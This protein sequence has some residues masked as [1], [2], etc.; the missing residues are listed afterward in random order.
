MGSYSSYFHF[1]IGEIESQR[2]ETI[3]S[4]GHS[5]RLW[6]PELEQMVWFQKAYYKHPLNTISILK[7]KAFISN[8]SALPTTSSAFLTEV[9]SF[10]IKKWNHGWQKR[11]YTVPIW[12]RLFPGNFCWRRGDSFISPSFSHLVAGMLIK[13]LN[14]DCDF[15]GGNIENAS[16]F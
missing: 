4:H 3:Q 9:L 14:C 8:H 5:G 15:S 2:V 1:I 10:V 7:S 6:H 12:F 11:G 13:I 16:L